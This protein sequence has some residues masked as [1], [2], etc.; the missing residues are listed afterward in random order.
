MYQRWVI[1]NDL[2]KKIGSQSHLI[3]LQ[4]KGHVFNLQVL[5]VEAVFGQS[6]H[7]F[8]IEWFTLLIKMT[9]YKLVKAIGCG[10]LAGQ[11]IKEIVSIQ[12][13]AV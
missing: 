11:E 13:T 6:K 2:A 4:G 9:E 8:V 7:N 12:R 1:L 5:Q 10:G 3:P